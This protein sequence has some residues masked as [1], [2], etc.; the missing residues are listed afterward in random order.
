MRRLKKYQVSC[1]FAAGAT[2]FG[3]AQENP[4]FTRLEPTETN[5][6]YDEVQP[7]VED[8]LAKTNSIDTK[9]V[10]AQKNSKT[11]DIKKTDL[12]TQRLNAHGLKSKKE[13]CP[14]LV[15]KRVDRTTISREDSIRT[16]SCDYFIYPNVG[17]EITV[18]VSDRRMKLQLI[19][20]Y[21]HDFANGSYRATAYGRHVIRLEYDSADRRPDV[22]D[23]TIH[24]D[25]KP[26]DAT[27]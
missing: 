12:V 7:V 15:Q 2:L 1:I 4:N 6:T 22:M 9:D 27:N 18:S 8:E 25:I 11:T 23:Y 24:V 20:P 13:A 21:D 17:D 19:M 10:N 26:T 5:S 3:C 14:K 16:K